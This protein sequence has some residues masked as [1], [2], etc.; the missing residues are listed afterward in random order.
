MLLVIWDWEMSP[1][2][3]HAVASVDN[4]FKFLQQYFEFSIFLLSL[5]LYRLLYMFIYLSMFV[6]LK[7]G[8]RNLICAACSFDFILEFSIQFSLLY[9]SPD[10]AVTLCNLNFVAIDT[11]LPYRCLPYIFCVQIR[12]SFS[13]VDTY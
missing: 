2:C 12:Y 5:S 9:F 13:S 1:F 10:F 8:R 4:C 6:S 7:S 11:C 3:V